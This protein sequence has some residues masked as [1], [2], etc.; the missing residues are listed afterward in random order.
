[1][2]LG[3]L[4]Y[5]C[6]EGVSPLRRATTLATLAAVLD[7]PVPP[8]VRSGPLAQVL[9][10]LLVRD[11]AARPDAARLDELLAQV[12]SGHTPRWDRPTLTAGPVP[13][14]PVPAPPTLPDSPLPGHPHRR[15]GAA[16]TA[17]LVVA[18]VAVTAL[19]LTLFPFDDDKAADRAGGSAPN[20]STAPATTPRSPSP[21]LS[22]NPVPTPS[23]PA[24]ST[25]GGSH[26]SPPAAGTGR[27]IAQLSSEPFSAGTAARDRH[28][29]DIRVSVPEALVLRSDD[30]ASLRPGY[31]VIY[32]PGPFADSR[33]AL[34]FC[35]ER[36]RT[37]TASCIGRYIGAGSDDRAR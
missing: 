14:P 33:A 29:A 12:E 8:P 15:R 10:S 3:M 17:A 4:L 21:R 25:P 31:W 32:A 20:T 36:G 23:E 9:Q 5:V 18:A 37:T 13:A 2:S 24:A 7:D 16:L 11:P 26:S 34:A 28:L 19:V 1:W 22:P 35:A 27:W 6:A 30:Y